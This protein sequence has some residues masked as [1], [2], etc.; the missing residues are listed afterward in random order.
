ML[1]FVFTHQLSCQ[2]RFV[3]VGQRAFDGQHDAVGD[4]GQEDGVLEGRPFDQELCEPADQVRLPEDE[5]GGGAL[6]L[7]LQLFL[8][9]HGVNFA[10]TEM[11][12]KKLL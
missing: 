3:P 6:L 7:L 9:R 8:L 11:V 5:E 4:D 12:Q 10:P 1:L 2:F